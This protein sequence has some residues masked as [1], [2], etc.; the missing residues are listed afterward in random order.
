[1][2]RD[3]VCLLAPTTD[4]EIRT[5][6]A[7]LRIAPLLN[8][9]RGKPAG[10]LDALV[11][12]TQKVIALTLNEDLVEVELN[13]VLVTKTSAVAVDALMIAESK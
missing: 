10:D 2:W 9:Y 6:L 3:T 4:A 13:P 1:L 8:G 7:S 12:L 5:A 11:A